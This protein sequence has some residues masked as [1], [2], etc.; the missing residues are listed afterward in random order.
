MDET[1]KGTLQPYKVTIMVEVPDRALTIL[2]VEAYFN[3]L[4]P[5]K[6]LEVVDVMVE[7]A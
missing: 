6:G 5:P 4:Q 1:K 3:G 2:E 7:K